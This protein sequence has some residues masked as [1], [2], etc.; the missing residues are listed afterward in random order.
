M[1]KYEYERFEISFQGWGL[2]GNIF[3]IDGYKEAITRRAEEGWRLVT[4]I[5]VVQRGEGLIESIDLVF[6]KENDNN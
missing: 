3:P 2:R 1:Y 6:E 5:P 4:C